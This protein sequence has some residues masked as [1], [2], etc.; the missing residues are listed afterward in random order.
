MGS[1]LFLITIMEPKTIFI[2][3]VTGVLGRQLTPLLQAQGHKIVALCRSEKNIEYCTR[4]G[5]EGRYGDLF[6]QQSVIDISKDCDVIMHL[7]TSMPAAKLPRKHDWKMNDRIREEGT[8]NLANAAI[9]NKVELFVQPS[10]AFV[11]GNQSGDFVTEA[12]SIP[13]EPVAMVKSALA[14]ERLLQEK[15]S[16]HVPFVILRFGM[17]Y[18]EDSFHTKSLIEDVKARKMP[19][20]GSGDNYMNFIHTEDA[21]TA[22]VYALNRS[23]HLANA[24]INVSDFNPVTSRELL[25]NLSSF[26]NVSGPRVIPKFLARLV[27]GKDIYHFAT[28]SYR[29]KKAE[30]MSAWEPKHKSFLTWVKSNYHL[31][32]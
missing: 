9:I 18:S 14:M 30:I 32:N 19:I 20:I 25:E 22:I 11:Y 26:L 12:T 29:L 2:T 6:D 16:Q 5:I 13:S 8:Y 28:D 23:Q 10:V 15:L 31:L 24:I 3:G 1:N 7:A 4:A 17:F 27:L 21:A